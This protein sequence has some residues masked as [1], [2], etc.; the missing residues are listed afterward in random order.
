[1]DLSHQ[2]ITGREFELNRR[3]YDPDTV[4][5]HL[6]EIATAVGSRESRI[7]ELE[8]MV[9]SLQAKVQDA[10]ESEEALRL[11]LKAA[12][13][14]KQELLA[15]AREQ[16]ESMEA[17]AAAKA[18]IVVIEAEAKAKDLLDGAETQAAA[19]RQGAS[20]QAQEVARA[21]LAESELLVARI[22][23]L[24]EQ[25]VAAESALHRLSLEAAPN[26]GTARDTLD[27]ALEQAHSIVES[28]AFLETAA[29]DVA[30]ETPLDQAEL[31]AEPFERKSMEESDIDES[32][33]P[34]ETQAPDES[35]PAAAAQ[36]E[37]PQPHP[38]QS[39]SPVTSDEPHDAAPHLEVVVPAEST[40]DIS[41]K[42]D[43]LL[44]ELR[45]VT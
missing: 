19:L 2:S 39:D 5:S 16:A 8:A 20:A 10:D 12:A 37:S 22:E 42:V 4:D 45:E 43:R 11:T 33:E 23:A 1:M 44:E 13:H 14:A 32:T 26:L 28:P 38:T 34:V 7:A 31:P 36:V 24:R 17:E 15:G 9:T 25:L 27:A 35:H 3:G 6:S 30:P 29:A 40:A 18:E 21:A 41:N